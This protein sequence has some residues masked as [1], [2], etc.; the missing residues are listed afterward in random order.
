MVCAVQRGDKR[1]LKTKDLE[2]AQKAFARLEREYLQ[3]RLIRVEK[4]ELMPFSDFVKEY[5]GERTGVV[6]KN[7][8]RAD[9]LAMQKFK[10]FYGDRPMRG[11]TE[12]KLLEFRA[13]LAQRLKKNSVNVYIRHL[14]TALK[15]AVKRK[16]IKE[17]PLD[18]FKTL[19]VD[20][21][22]PIYMTEEDVKSLFDKAQE[23]EF[24]K[25]TIPVMVC[26]GLSRI[27]VCKTIVITGTTIQYR[28][29]KTE[30]LIEIPI[31]DKLRP[32]IAGMKGIVR[33]TPWKHPDTVGH[34]FLEVARAAGLKGIT[35]HK[36][37]HTFATLCLKAGVDIATV[38]ELLGHADVSITKK[39]YGHIVDELKQ[40]AMKKFNAI[41]K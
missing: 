41:L 40:Q 1:S 10:D 19:K 30:K 26:T 31:I 12:K 34:K 7:T 16:Y 15:L 39:F 25:T 8:L 33:L 5:T 17:N 27:D 3:G 23:Y 36:V 4:E 21:G 2:K 18:A 38:S 20:L 11:I 32:Y 37:R 35:T 13:F 9:K 22:K 29:H 24:M 14:K 28:R 6:K